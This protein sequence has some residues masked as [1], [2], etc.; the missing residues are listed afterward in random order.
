MLPAPN[1][2]EQGEKGLF[3][4]SSVTP[5]RVFMVLSAA[6]VDAC[7]TVVGWE[8]AA[9]TPRQ[10]WGASGERTWLQR[11]VPAGEQLVSQV[12]TLQ[13][14]LSCTKVA[15]YAPLQPAQARAS[16]TPPGSPT[17]PVLWGLCLP[18]AADEPGGWLQFPRALQSS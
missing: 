16:T 7:G 17:P 12:T 10:N 8:H 15:L 18:K 3:C 6:C 9:D 1:P 5:S 2:A 13:G 11:A 14:Q 4:N